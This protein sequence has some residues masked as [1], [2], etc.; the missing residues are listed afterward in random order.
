MTGRTAACEKKT[1]QQMEDDEIDD[2]STDIWKENWF[3]K[4]EKSPAE[5]EDLTNAQSAANYTITYD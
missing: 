5:L 4:Y 1:N 2:E 3:K